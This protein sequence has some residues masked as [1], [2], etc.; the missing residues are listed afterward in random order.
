MAFWR[1]KSLEFLSL[2]W[3]KSSDRSASLK[4]A[5]AVAKLKGAR[6]SQPR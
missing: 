1:L 6:L 2:A 4:E 3:L 5:M